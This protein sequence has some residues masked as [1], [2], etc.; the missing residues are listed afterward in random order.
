MGFTLGL[1]PLSSG[2][3]VSEDKEQ[4]ERTA[5]W[6]ELDKWDT[7]DTEHMNAHPMYPSV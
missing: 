6:M 2:L 5:L 4:I 7:F 1:I 3:T